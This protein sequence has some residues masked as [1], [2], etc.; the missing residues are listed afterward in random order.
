MVDRFYQYIII[1]VAVQLIE[2]L[3]FKYTLFYFPFQSAFLIE[4]W[5]IN[6]G[7]EK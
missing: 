1:S 7:A 4:K 5:R 6:K 2:I 3:A